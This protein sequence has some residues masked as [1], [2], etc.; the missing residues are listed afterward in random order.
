MAQTG[1]MKFDVEVTVVVE[2]E[3]DVDPAATVHAISQNINSRAAAVR[4]EISNTCA[5][6]DQIKSVGRF[7]VKRRRLLVDGEDED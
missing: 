4:T 1:K 2:C 3:V 5:G 6:T 7:V